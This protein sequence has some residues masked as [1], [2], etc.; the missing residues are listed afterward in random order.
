MRRRCRAMAVLMVHRD[1]SERVTTLVEANSADVLGYLVRRTSDPDEAADLFADTLTVLWRRARNLPDSDVEARMW[2]FGVARNTLLTRSRARRRRTALH[3]RLQAQLREQPQDDGGRSAAIHDAL[4]S[5]DPLDQE[6]IRLV[7]WDG[8]SQVEAAQLLKMPD[9]T[10]RSR[11]LRARRQ[12]KTALET[13][14]LTT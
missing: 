3:S 10:V 12:L 4:A 13:V 9:A 14:R 6:I 5:L 7:H 8:F 1:I 11:H 2:I